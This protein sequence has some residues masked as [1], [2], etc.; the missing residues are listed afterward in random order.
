[1]KVFFYLEFENFLKGSGIYSSFENQKTILARNKI[2]FISKFGIENDFDILHFHL[3]GPK[4]LYLAKKYKKFGKKIIFQ[5]HITAEDFRNSFRFSNLIADIILKRYL[6]YVY[7]LADVI[8]APS[9]YT[10]NILV[11]YGLDNKKIIVLSNGIDLEKF[12]ISQ[13]KRNN[14]RKIYNLKGIVVFSV[15]LVLPKRKGVETFLNVAKKFKYNNFIWFG[16]ILNKLIVSNIANNQENVK[17]SGFVEDIVAACNAGDIFLFPSYEEN[18]G[19]AILEAAAAGKVLIVRD[20]PVF[21]GW[22]EHKRNCLKARNDEEF[23]RAVELLIKNSSMRDNL[24]KQ[25]LKLA[26]DNDLVKIGNRLISIY[27]SII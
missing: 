21:R 25:S 27:R 5:A 16:K 9:V 6:P 24:S 2:N 8:I 17:F 22:L 14:Y 13:I 11:N 12:K 15:G 1:M 23:I 26:Q 20:L 4:S 19:I 10:K 3:P 18:Q 7:S